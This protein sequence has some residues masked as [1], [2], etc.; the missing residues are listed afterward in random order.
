MGSLKAI[1]VNDYFAGS[2]LF[3]YMNPGSSTDPNL[4]SGMFKALDMMS[5]EFL[6]GGFSSIVFDNGLKVVFD[7]F[8]IKHLVVNKYLKLDPGFR[9]TEPLVKKSVDSFYLESS[10][11]DGFIGSRLVFDNLFSKLDFKPV[12]FSVFDYSSNELVYSVEY[13]PGI[14]YELS[15]VPTDLGVNY[16]LIFDSGDELLGDGSFFRSKFSELGSLIKSSVKVLG[17]AILQG[18]VGIIDSAIRPLIDSF[19]AGYNKTRFTL[20]GDKLVSDIANLPSFDDTKKIEV[21]AGAK[22]IFS[23]LNGSAKYLPKGKDGC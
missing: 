19:V 9:F 17:P 8:F 7:S 23:A 10:V 4:I 6:G 2:N 22:S 15:D 3:S 12:K 5:R 16:C 20:F 1:L 11:P 13:K 18:D 21:L 14:T